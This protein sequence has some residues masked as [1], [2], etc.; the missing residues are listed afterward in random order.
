MPSALP[1]VTRC[2]CTSSP[3]TEMWFAM[4]HRKHQ[5]SFVYLKRI[6]DQQLWAALWTHYPPVL[7]LNPELA[8]DT[9]WDKICALRDWKVN[10]KHHVSLGPLLIHEHQTFRSHDA[11]WWPEIS[12]Q[13][14]K[15]RPP[16][17]PEGWIHCPDYKDVCSNLKGRTQKESTTERLWCRERK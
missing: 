14:L 9:A 2:W 10:I 13:W 17:S 3:E 1:N 8:T 4:S 12:S 6:W 16:A 7:S 15:L 5:R 11:P